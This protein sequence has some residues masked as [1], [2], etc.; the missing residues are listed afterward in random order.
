[1][2]KHLRTQQQYHPQDDALWRTTR[3][4][5]SLVKFT[6]SQIKYAS[7]NNGITRSVGRSGQP[8]S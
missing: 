4:T 5:G 1:M 7:P 8:F 6:W 3:N 2:R